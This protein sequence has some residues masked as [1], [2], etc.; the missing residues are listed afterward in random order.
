MLFSSYYNK[1]YEEVTSSP[2]LSLNQKIISPLEKV[3]CFNKLEP[4]ELNE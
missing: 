1:L 4:L 3:A 2:S